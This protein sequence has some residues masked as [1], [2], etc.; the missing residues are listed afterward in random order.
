MRSPA[1]MR[2]HTRNVTDQQLT[3]LIDSMKNAV[4]DRRRLS[5]LLTEVN[6]DDKLSGRASASLSCFITADF[7]TA[8]LTSKGG[9]IIQTKAHTRETIRKVLQMPSLL[10]T[11]LR[12]SRLPHIWRQAKI[13]VP[14]NLITIGWPQWIQQR[15]SYQRVTQALGS[16]PPGQ[17][18]WTT[19]SS[20]QTDFRRGRSTVD[21]FSHPGCR[22]QLLLTASTPV[23]R[24]A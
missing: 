23:R 19:T 8:Q 10:L 21:D 17:S 15:L 7:I 13:I 5:S 1:K 16:R 6:D 20:K 22:R 14:P 12:C 4:R 9:I 11:T 2:K 3:F 18:Y 24:R